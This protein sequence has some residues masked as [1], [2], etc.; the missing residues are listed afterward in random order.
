MRALRNLAILGAAATM[1]AACAMDA[2]DAKLKL[3]ANLNAGAEVP[4]VNSTAAGSATVNLD[5][6]TKTLSWVITYRG[7]SGPARAAHFHGPAA[8][9]ANAGVAVPITVRD[10]P[11]QGSALLNDTQMADLLA[12]KWYINIHTAA[13]QGGE[14][15]GQVVPT[16]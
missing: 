12:G 7:L 10:S 9:S 6:A 8:P 2:G 4:P 3:A 14:I 16:N 15:R 1:L 11:M 5:K 13:H